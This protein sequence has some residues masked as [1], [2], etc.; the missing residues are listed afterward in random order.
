MN[1][2]TATEDAGTLPAEEPGARRPGRGRWPLVVWAVLV[3]ASALL[4]L[5][6]LDGLDA[7]PPRVPGSPSARAAELLTRGM[8]RV[9]T[10]QVMLAFDSPVLRASDEP[11]RDAVLDT[12]RALTAR[13][14]VGGAL[15]VPE[16]PGQDLHHAYLLLGVNGDQRQRQRDM[17]VLRDEARRAAAHASRGRVTVSLVGLTAVVSELNRGDIDDLRRAETVTVPLALLLLTVGLGS[18]GSALVPLLVAGAGVAVGVGA[19]SLLSLATDVDTL[20]LAVTTTVGFG[21]GL[22]YAL[23]VLV[24]YRRARTEGATP[25]AAVAHASATA[26]RAVRWCALAVLLASAALLAVPLVYVRTMGLAALIATGVTY[27]AAATLLPRVLPRVDP[28]LGWGTLPGRR[29]RPSP[30]ASAGWASWARRLMRS[31]WPFLLAALAV[32]ALATAPALGLRLWMGIDRPALAHSDAGRGMARMERDRIAGGSV[33]ALPHAGT[34]GPV[35]TTALTEKLRT[36]PRVAFTAAFDNG[37]DLTVLVIVQRVPADSEDSAALVR[38]VRSSA[39]HTLSRGHPVFVGGAS[40]ALIDLRAALL[41]ALRRAVPLVLAVSFVLLVAVFRSVLI[42]FKAIAMNL[43]S[44]AAALGLLTAWSPGGEVDNVIPLLAFTIVF[45]LSMD[46]EVFLVHAIT[47][48]YRGTGD[49]REAVAH[50]LS[51]TARPISLAAGA[52]AVVF[53]GLLTAGRQDIRQLGFAVSVAVLLDAT[54]IRIV[55]VPTLMRLMGHRNWWFPAPLARFLP[56]VR[57]ARPTGGHPYG[58]EPQGVPN[59]RTYERV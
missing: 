58:Q 16:Q 59:S 40:A 44:I 27:A 46:Y 34:A 21:L 26:G 45:G 55:V 32:L 41:A 18:L 3:L 13:P 5:V 47:E 24:R 49:S 1:S 8:P 20:M 2:G 17:P 6:R 7:P 9:G 19:L 37:K 53:A 14:A 43:L 54:L 25:T 51:R 10:E 42:P 15:P 29:G 57:A 48:H 22:D 36:D 23:L 33:V 30:P 31:P 4:A 11:Y 28:L 52:M 38:D 50:G 39:E 12:A 35:D 56:P